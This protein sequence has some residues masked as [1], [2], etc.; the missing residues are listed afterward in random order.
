MASSACVSLLISGIGIFDTICTIRHFRLG[1]DL[2]R[3]NQEIFWTESV[4]FN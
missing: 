1:H 4:E 3:P 2:A